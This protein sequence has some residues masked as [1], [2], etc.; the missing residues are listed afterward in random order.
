MEIKAVVV[1]GVCALVVTIA[2]MQFTQATT[3]IE[4][5]EASSGKPKLIYTFWSRATHRPWEA[6]AFVENGALEYKDTTKTRCGNSIERAREIWYTSNPG[7]AGVDTVTFP[8]ILIN[9]II[10]K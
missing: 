7:F 1:P 8:R 6:T 3:R 4:H 9:S 5:A 10:A 2:A